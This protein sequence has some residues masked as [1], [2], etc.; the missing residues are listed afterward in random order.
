M[1]NKDKKVAIMQPYVFPYIGY[2]QLIHSVDVFVFYDDVNFIK[3]GWI[4]RNQIL[5]ANESYKFTIPLIGASQNKLINEIEVFWDSK[6][7][8]KLL[9]QIEQSYRFAP[10]FTEVFALINDVFAQKSNLISDLAILSI[11]KV[12]DYIGLKRVFL[13]SSE[14]LISKD[15]GRADRLIAITKNLHSLHYINAVNGQELYKKEYFKNQEVEL[16]FLSPNLSPYTQGAN[17]EFV[18]FLS[19]I[20][21]LMWKDKA[22]IL[23]IISSYKII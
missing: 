21:L 8:K 17:T 9:Q 1:E 20:D 14:L 12:C 15:L 13:K 16:G 22:E 19:I 11:S 4:N 7:D 10:N 6:F 18:A 2:F 5:L 3:K 23:S